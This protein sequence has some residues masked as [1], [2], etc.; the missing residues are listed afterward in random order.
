M[1]TAKNAEAVS[2]LQDFMGRKASV[3]VVDERVFNGR[4]VAIDD[5]CNCVFSSA[6]EHTPKGDERYI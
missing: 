4:F 2:I 5:S 6:T 1:A 3:T